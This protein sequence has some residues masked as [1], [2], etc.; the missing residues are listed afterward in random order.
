MRNTHFTM[1]ASNPQ[2]QHNKHQQPHHAHIIRRAAESHKKERRKSYLE[3][4]GLLGGVCVAE[5]FS[6]ADFRFV[7][8]RADLHL[9]PK[10]QWASGQRASPQQRLYQPG[11]R[12]ASRC[13]Q[14][15]SWPLP[16]GQRRVTRG[17][18][19]EDTPKGRALCSLC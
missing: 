11:T 1:H 18:S 14:S 10:P 4:F 7:W 3:M 9:H 16:A 6:H 15:E 12:R 17:N 2:H 5:T 8:P 13:A 19:P